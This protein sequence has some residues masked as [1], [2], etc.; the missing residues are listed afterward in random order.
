M[1]YVPILSHH[2]YQFTKWQECLKTLKVLSFTEPANTKKMMCMG[3]G[4]MVI[5]QIYQENVFMFS[6][7]I[8]SVL[9][10][11]NAVKF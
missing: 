5:H 7:P 9:T 8:F 11:G 2:E 1:L 4:A 3:G 6:I 10:L